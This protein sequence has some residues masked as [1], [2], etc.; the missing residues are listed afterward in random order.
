MVTLTLHNI[1]LN[2][3]GWKNYLFR[4]VQNV[5][6][7]MKHTSYLYKQWRECL[8]QQ[9]SSLDI[10][11]I[12]KVKSY[13]SHFSN[14]TDTSKDWQEGRAKAAVCFQAQTITILELKRTNAVQKW[15][16]TQEWNWG[17]DLEQWAP[18]LNFHMKIQIYSFK[19]PYSGSFCSTLIVGKSV[20]V[21]WVLVHGLS[22][23]S[24][25]TLP[26]RLYIITV[27]LY[28]TTSHHPGQRLETARVCCIHQ[29][30]Q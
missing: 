4:Q 11:I 10:I 21:F 28:P 27:L 14:D 23:D 15:L 24:D 22:R 13:L 30:I 29:Q 2:I 6:E 25:K 9:H 12:E 7:V 5:H 16:T 20:Y 18:F 17:Q 1:I 8:H 19:A 3:L 26:T